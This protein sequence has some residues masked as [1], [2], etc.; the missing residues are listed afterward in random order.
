M[1][2]PIN[3]LIIV[4]IAILTSNAHAVP[5]FTWEGPWNVTLQSNCVSHTDPQHP[6]VCTATVGARAFDASAT[7]DRQILDTSALIRP[8]QRMPRSDQ[9]WL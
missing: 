4:M 8:W 2:H 6:D 5:S 1:T 9:P 7:Q 3:L